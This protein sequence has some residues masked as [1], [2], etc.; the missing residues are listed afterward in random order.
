MLRFGWLAICFIQRIHQPTTLPHPSLFGKHSSL[1]PRAEFKSM[2]IPFD[3]HRYACDNQKNYRGRRSWFIS[4]YRAIFSQPFDPS[5]MERF[6]AELWLLAIGQP[7]QYMAN[8]GSDFRSLWIHI[9]QKIFVDHNIYP[10]DNV[11]FH[12]H[13]VTLQSACDHPTWLG[14]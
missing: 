7:P 12:N 3:P 11:N 8:L 1:D 4:P 6:W 10:S 14:D 13:L 2:T 9:G 5:A